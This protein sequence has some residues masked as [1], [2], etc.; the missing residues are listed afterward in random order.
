MTGTTKTQFDSARF[1]ATEG[2]GRTIRHNA[3]KQVFY[4]QGG[5]AD[6]VF[7]LQSGHA[8]LTVVSKR[9]KEATVTL[10]VA[11]DFF[12][13]ESMA[14]VKA[15]RTASASAVSVCVALRI[16]RAEMLSVLHE[17]HAFSDLFMKFILT[18]GIRTQSDLV[19]QLFNSS[20]RRLARTLLLMAHFGGP[21]EPEPL[22]P[23]VTQ[24]T[25][26]ELIGTTRSR[27]SFFMNRFRKLGYIE[28]NG[29][30]LVHTSLLNM[31]LRD[32]LPEENASRPKLLDPRPSPA[33]TARRVKLV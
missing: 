9:G 31:V 21:G 28:Y 29:R 17:E 14:A 2:P 24:E 6:S 18:R 11:G 15:L 4:S 3:A 13:E 33:R 25:L 32:D 16:E 7:Y 26:A 8:K 30:I 27:V 1:L 10:L 23:V 20:E 12:G 5:P 19:D 22:I